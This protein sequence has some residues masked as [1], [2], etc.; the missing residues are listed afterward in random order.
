MPE[1]FDAL[2]NRQPRIALGIYASGAPALA[3]S[4]AG[5]APSAPEDKTPRKA[6]T[7]TA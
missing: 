1:L 6:M 4:S 7:M 5:L 2:L 3:I